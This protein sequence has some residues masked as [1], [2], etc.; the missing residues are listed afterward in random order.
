MCVWCTCS[1]TATASGKG[2]FYLGVRE[3][4]VSAGCSGRWFLECLRT[5]RRKF[6]SSRL[7]ATASQLAVWVKC[8]SKSPRLTTSTCKFCCLVTKTS[9]SRQDS[10]KFQL[11]W[12]SCRNVT[13]CFRVLYVIY[14]QVAD[15]SHVFQSAGSARLQEQENTQAEDDHCRAKRR[16]FRDRVDSLRAHWATLAKCASLCRT[17]TWSWS[18]EEDSSSSLQDDDVLCGYFCLLTLRNC[19][20]CILP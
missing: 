20:T 9:L 4:N 16:G 11:H 15:G 8:S 1:S 18:G 10:Q 13:S 7:A 14:L 17:M 2:T 19:V 6:S 5:Y 3:C 12:F